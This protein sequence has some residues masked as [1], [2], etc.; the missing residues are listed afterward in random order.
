MPG[1]VHQWRE[2]SITI[3]GSINNNHEANGHSAENIQGEKAVRDRHCSWLWLQPTNIGR[4]AGVWSVYGLRF[5]V[6]CIRKANTKYRLHLVYLLHLKN[7]K[8]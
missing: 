8:P 2:S 3:A 4:N 5:F 1:S 7:E 6:S